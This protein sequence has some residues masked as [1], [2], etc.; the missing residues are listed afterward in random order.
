MTT[1]NQTETT[2]VKDKPTVPAKKKK[3]CETPAAPLFT[4]IFLFA[5][6]AIFIGVGIFMWAG[7]KATF[8]G[9]LLIVFGVSFLALNIWLNFSLLSKKKSPETKQT[10]E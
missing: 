1:Q 6:C 4:C 2:E 8:G 9:V 5:L 3:K 7:L 10:K